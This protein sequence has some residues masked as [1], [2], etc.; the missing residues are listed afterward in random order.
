VLCREINTKISNKTFENVGEIKTS[1]K[2]LNLLNEK[3]KIRLNSTIPLRIFI[4]M[5]PI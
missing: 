5:P 4:I 3:C 1:T 2:I